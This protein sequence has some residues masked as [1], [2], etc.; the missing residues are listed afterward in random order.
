MHNSINGRRMWSFLTTF[1]AMACVSGTTAW[2]QIESQAQMK[3]S[4]TKFGDGGNIPPQF[5]CDGENTSPDLQ[6]DAVP[7]AAKSLLLIVDDPDAPKGVFTHWLLWNLKP[8]SKEILANSP[9]QDARQG[10]NDFGK[11][12]YSGPCPPSGSHRY[13]FRLYALDFIPTLSPG[14]NR[15]VVD[16]GIEGHVLSKA[17][18]VGIYARPSK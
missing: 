8:D 12:K 6:I 5:T 9:P 15:K 11:Q 16:K 13:Y 14:S 1:I 18:L 2:S 10:T 17:V 7:A 4:S 3:I